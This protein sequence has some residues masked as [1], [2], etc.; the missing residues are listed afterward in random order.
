LKKYLSK[1]GLSKIQNLKHKYGTTK[2]QLPKKENGV[3]SSIEKRPIPPK[4][5]GS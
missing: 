2:A 3:Q 5:I 4:D 1:T